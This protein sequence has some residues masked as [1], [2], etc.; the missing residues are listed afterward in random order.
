MR[1]GIPLLTAHSPRPV[2][3]ALGAFLRAPPSPS[4]PL[5]PTLAWTS[6]HRRCSPPPRVSGLLKSLHLS[7]LESLYDI[8]AATVRTSFLMCWR[9][10]GVSSDSLVTWGPLGSECGHPRGCIHFSLC[11]RRIWGPQGLRGCCLEQQLL[12]AMRHREHI[13]C[14]QGS[15]ERNLP[16][17]K[18]CLL[19]M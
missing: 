13:F 17:T 2:S 9:T 4:S 14:P 8:L 6:L 1:A 18:M 15:P 12:A 11:R 10:P 7:S 3:W 16:G 5:C 19:E